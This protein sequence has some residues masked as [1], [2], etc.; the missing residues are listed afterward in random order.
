MQCVKEQIDALH[1]NF[2]P[3]T[4]GTSHKLTQVLPEGFGKEAE[5]QEEPGT[6]EKIFAMLAN[7]AMFPLAIM[8]ILGIAG[9]IGGGL[10]FK[11]WLHSGILLETRPDYRLASRYGAG[12]SRHVRYLEGQEAAKTKTIF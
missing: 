12:V 4:A 8:G 7:P 5:E 2:E 9:L 11:R 10:W 6:R 1:Y 3:L